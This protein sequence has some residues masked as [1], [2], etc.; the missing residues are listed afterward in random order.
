MIIHMED[1]MANTQ[2][3]IPEVYSA[4]NQ[5]NIDGAL[6]L[7][8]GASDGPRHRKAAVWAARLVPAYVT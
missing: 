3:L 5:R 1:Y 6:A 4:F 8:S 7:M 2:T